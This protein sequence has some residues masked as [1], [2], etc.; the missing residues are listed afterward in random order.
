MYVGTRGSY[1]DSR[2]ERI[3]Q[4]GTAIALV[5]GLLWQLARN[6]KDPRDHGSRSVP[7]VSRV[8]L[9]GTC[10]VDSR[11]ASRSDDHP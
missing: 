4:A 2:L 3:I 11:G 6:D 7:S 8:D 5:Y 1:T 10:R 9:G